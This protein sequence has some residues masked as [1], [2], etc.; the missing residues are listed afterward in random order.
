[1]DDILSQ[2]FDACSL[3]R[4][5]ESSLRL[6]NVPTDPHYLLG[7]CEE[8]VG[9]FNEAIHRLHARNMSL[10]HS[11]MLF[12]EAPSSQQ[13]PGAGEGCSHGTG[14]MQVADLLRT[15]AVE[16]WRLEI[17]S[18][19]AMGPSSYPGTPNTG[20]ESLVGGGGEPRLGAETALSGRRAD[21]S[22]P[23]RS[24]RTRKDAGTVTKRVP[25][26]RTGNMEMPPDDGYTWRKYGQKDILN[27][28]FPRSYYR[29]THRSYY[30]CEAKK[31]V[32]RLDDDP[33]TFEV[34]YCGTHTCQTSPTP[35]LI[36]T[37]VP[38]AIGNNLNDNENDGGRQQGAS[39]QS[40][41]I[42]LPNWLD[43][44]PRNTG[45]LLVPQSGAGGSTSRHVGQQQGGRDIDG[46]VA[47]L[48][49]AMFNSA[50]SGS[51]M[52]CIFSRRQRSL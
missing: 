12:G 29:C 48:A 21:G 6:S 37:L 2:V 13:D 18:A 47:E 49:D 41:S 7:S 24:S 42:R 46:S 9:A 22:V 19:A 51:S 38:S 32:Q 20:V 10:F 8:I 34:T 45:T 33:N 40:V 23:H 50:S 31:K 30:G 15:P 44:N 3:A 25:A 14:Y 28:R 26:L 52:D 35:I 39:P 36:P 17:K 43:G 16:A 5:L 11:Q 4:E 27:S 1:M